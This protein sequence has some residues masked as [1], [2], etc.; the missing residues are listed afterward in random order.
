ML[1]AALLL[2]AIAHLGSAAFASS[3]GPGPQRGAHFDVCVVGGG[4]A[5]VAATQTLIE[6]GKR[7]TLLE[8]EAFVG[9][10]TAPKYVD[11]SGFRVLMGAIVICSW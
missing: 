4:P 10:Q 8:R 3:A 5:G 7:V 11:P 1:L 2:C 6:K 9:G